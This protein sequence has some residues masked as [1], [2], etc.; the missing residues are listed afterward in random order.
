[1]SEAPS[2]KPY[3]IRALFD[4]CV[5]HGFT[6]Y[7]AV[8]VNEQV[9]VPMD[10]VNNREIVLNISPQACQDLNMDNEWVSFKARFAGIS[11]EIDVP[12]GNVMAIYA[13]ENGQGMSFPVDR[14]SPTPTPEKNTTISKGKPSLKIVK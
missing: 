13:K 8:F 1:M 6:P 14:S 7:L 2:T 3:L 9:N 10:Y 5:D 11:R 4:W 12:M